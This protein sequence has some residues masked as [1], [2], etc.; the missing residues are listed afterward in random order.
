MRYL[1]AAAFAAG[2]VVAGQAHAADLV[3][4]TKAPPA[5][6]APAWTWT[7][8]NQAEYASWGSGRG[9]PST[10]LG[11]AHGSQFYNP[12]GLSGSGS[13]TS[14]W[15]L[16][17]VARGGYVDASQTLGKFG[18]TVS[19]ATDTT[20][21]ATT[22][23]TG[24]GGWMPYA[25]L[26]ANLP[27]GDSVL[28]GTRTFARMDPD[29]VPVALYGEGFNIGPTLGVQIPVNSEL[30]VIVNSGLTW[31]GAYYKEGAFAA[32]TATTGLPILINPSQIWTS[33]VTGVWKHDKWTVQGTASY[34]ME[35]TN[36]VSHAISYRAGDRLTLSG[37]GSYAWDGGW[38]T[39]AD[40]YFVHSA[41]NDVPSVLAPLVLV[42]EALDSNNDVFRI[43]LQHLYTMP[44]AGG[45]L[46]AGPIGSFLYRDAN[47]W[48]PTTLLFIP[49]KTLYYLGATATYMPSK[50]FSM[51]GRVERIWMDV[52]SA[53]GSAVPSFGTDGW[54]A[55]FTLTLNAP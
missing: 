31:R 19:T 16:D 49:A 4:A 13:L 14:N 44:Y 29:L 35:D 30:T 36:Y 37:S 25:T 39:T 17:V 15:N 27:T 54:L 9:F 22:T 47:S 18:G 51:N 12:F 11:P 20:L 6:A 33:A 21:S 38:T 34:A 3:M 32:A 10:A 26:M 55:S 48:D 28:S 46:T 7:L 1:L 43:N 41:R 52:N 8:D 45:T 23:Y 40:G 42:P 50:S 5:P 53:P 2:I 24:F